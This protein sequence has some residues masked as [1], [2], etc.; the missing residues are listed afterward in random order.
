MGTHAIA[1]VIALVLNATA[2]LLIKFGS[3]GLGDELA[4][5]G[6]PAS[7][8]GWLGL[9]LRHWVLFLGL[10]CFAAN[11]VFYAYALQRLPISI[12]Y[13]VMVATGFAIIVAVAGW[14]LGETLTVGQWV[15]VAAILGGVVLVSKDAARQMEVRKPDGAGAT[16]AD[17][18]RTER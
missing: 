4:A 17:P 12:A 16:T 14:L 1:L 3:K 2:N 13:P 6:T 15:G 9:F 18:A 11:V 5:T 8:V 10:G 7:L